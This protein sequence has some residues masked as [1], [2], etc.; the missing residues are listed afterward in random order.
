MRWKDYFYFQKGD[1]IAII[2]LLI[3][4]ILSGG[5]YIFTIPDSNA[6][7]QE[8]TS[9]FEKEFETFISELKEDSVRNVVD[10]VSYPDYTEYNKT[11]QY[12]I[13][14]KLKQGETIELNT[15]DTSELKK[16]P[17]IGSSFAGRIVKYREALGGYLNIEQLKEVWGMDDYLY[18]DIRPY[19]TLEPKIRKLKINSASFQ[20]LLKHPYI[21]YKQAQI[22]IDI[23]E[24]KDNISSV[25]R[26]GLL[27]EFA[28]KDINRLAPYLSF[29]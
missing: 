5:I 11:V 12:P 4:I 2:L 26:L 17:K 14:V 21:N 10:R 19:I 28:E 8:S 20:E 13:Q 6:E 25:N 22:I 1:K 3:L 15:A 24:R 16:I 18:N 23:R 29:D 7:P 27:D 9:A